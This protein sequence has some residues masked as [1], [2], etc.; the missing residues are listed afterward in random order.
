MKP[1]NLEEALAGTPVITRDGI[2]V[3]QLT[4]FKDVKNHYPILGIVEGRLFSW[5]ELGKNRCYGSNYDLFIADESLD[6]LEDHPAL[7]TSKLTLENPEGFSK[8]S[9]EML[10][11]IIKIEVRK[12][13]KERNLI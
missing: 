10:I 5:D 1:F 7:Y 12:D 13:L 2:P 3:K 9:L 4:Y 8:M 11:A 6:N